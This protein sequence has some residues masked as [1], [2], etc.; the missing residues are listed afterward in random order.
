[1]GLEPAA[2]AAEL[3]KALEGLVN[4][5]YKQHHLVDGDD[6]DRRIGALRD[7]TIV[8]EIVANHMH[9]IRLTGNRALHPKAGEPVLQ[10]GDIYPSITAFVA[11]L[12][13][14]DQK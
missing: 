5:L 7:H 9:T 10:S 13:W 3:R 6:L 4:R 2:A 8:P 14:L 1:M 12:E 11:I